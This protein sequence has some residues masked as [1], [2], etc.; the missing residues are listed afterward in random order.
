[1]AHPVPSS[2]LQPSPVR[3]ALWRA[4]VLCLGLALSGCGKAAKPV[5]PPPPVVG[6]LTVHPQAVPLDR[7]LTGRLSA[8]YSA[9]VVA[10]V[11]GVL[12]RRDY[13]EG[14]AVKQGQ[15]LFEIDPTYYR[16]VLN[17]DLAVLAG[18]KATYENDRITAARDH[19]LFPTGSISEQTLDDADAAER[20]AAAKVQAD[21]AAV[22]GARINLGYTKVTSP[23]SGIAGQQLVTPGAV[24]GSGTT[25]NGS[26]GTLLTSVQQVDRLYANFAISAAD[27]LTLRA[28]Q[29]V[30][31]A[32]EDETKV[33]LIL[34]NGAAYGPQGTLD[35]SDVSVN[36][37]TGAVDLR[38]LVPNPSQILLP[39]MYVTL[40][41]HFGTEKNVFLVPQQA[42][43]RDTE[44]AY[45]L[46]VDAKGQVA[47]KDVTAETSLGT[48]WIVTNGLD[49]GD[50]VIVTGLQG[51]QEG[52]TV[53]V[54]DW[55]PASGQ[56]QP[57]SGGNKR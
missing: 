52:A 9:N 28:A 49:D 39:G 13:K 1:M 6:V 31:L 53:K 57:A 27:L 17:N 45:A 2:R 50:R 20:S 36:P 8:Y 7:S 21:Q 38:A 26:G 51:A 22:D 33:K 46:V 41:V 10:R 4:S 29:N 44:S 5:A 16:S 25:D 56:G 19:R 42:V 3:A 48:D 23:I 30:A 34:P 55:Q 43:Q 35:F 37:T 18:D 40:V 47:R 14:G 32:A 15:L 11:S 54:T 24:V 12:L